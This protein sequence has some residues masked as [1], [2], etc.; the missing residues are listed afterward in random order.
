MLISKTKLSNKT[1]HCYNCSKDLF[2]FTTINNFKL[3]SL[4]SDRFYCNSD[5]NES[6]LTLKPPM[7]LSYLFNE[8]NSFSSDINNTSENVINSNYYDIDTGSD[9]KR[10]Y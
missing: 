5:S 8:F 3:Y 1:W 4:V 7:N 9:L 2:P 6:C 10:I